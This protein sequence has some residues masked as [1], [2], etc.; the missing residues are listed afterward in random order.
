M[1]KNNGKPF[2][3]NFYN[4]ILVLHLCDMLFS[5]ITLMNLGHTCLF[6]KIFCTVY[7][8]YKEGN[9]VTPPHIAQ[10]KHAVLVKTKEM[11]KSKII[12]HRRK[13][14]L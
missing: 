3:V 12:A 2:T 1:I 7:F 5:I 4:V 6:H 8:R 14:A 11:S 9:L 13:I 10:K